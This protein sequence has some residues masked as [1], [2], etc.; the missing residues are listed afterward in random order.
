MRRF[1]LTCALLSC[2]L[3]A[4]PA[5]APAKTGQLVTF[6][7]PRELVYEPA[8]RAEAFSTLESLGVR[9]LRIVLYWKT[10]APRPRSRL[11][12]AFDPTDP[13][14]YAWGGYDAAIDGARQRGWKVLLTV[15]GPVPRWATNGARD[16]VTRPRTAE[17]EAFM[18]AVAR[19]YAGKVAAYSI[20]N[21]PNHPQFLGPQFDR[22]GRPVAPRVY[23]GL[24]LAGIR[25][26]RAGGQ[27]RIPVLMGETAPVG[28]PRVVAPLDFLRGALCLSRSYRRSRRCGRVPVDGYAHH[29]YTTKA[30]PFYRPRIATN[31]TIAVVGRLTR[32]LDR[33]ARAGAI[34]RRLPVWLTE[35]GI[36]SVPDPSY[37]VSQTRQNEYRAISERIA[38]RNRRVAA[39]SQYLLRDDRPLAGRRGPERFGGFESGLRTTR[40]RDKLA[41]PGFRLPLAAQRRGRRVALWGLVR[42]AAG[43]TIAVLE[44][45]SGRRFRRLAVVRTRSG[46]GWSRTVRHRAGRRYRVVWTAPGG[47]RW[48]SPA[49]RA[50]R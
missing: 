29:A 19:R 15:S 20:W 42:P 23:R 30:G 7:A 6:E 45:S 31:V 46:G 1:L 49:V 24:L 10:V 44:A 37:G 2:A 16:H 12:P 43:R 3:A 28:T 21:E 26:L 4:L 22:R 9:S 48:R 27:G 36:Q 14:G 47:R 38:W 40:G 39:F 17:F 33:A 8:L 11:R 34:R 18:T 50:Y 35:F 13:A 41:L 5:T 32:A 25:G